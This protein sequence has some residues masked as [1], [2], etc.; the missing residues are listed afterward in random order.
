MLMLLAPAVHAIC[1]LAILY[2]PDQK[3]YNTESLARI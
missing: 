2:E 1:V 3:K